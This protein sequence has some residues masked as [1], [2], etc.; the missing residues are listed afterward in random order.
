MAKHAKQRL[1]SSALITSD[2]VCTIEGHWKL[3]AGAPPPPTF[4]F[5][6]GKGEEDWSIRITWELADSQS[7]TVR[8]L[9][10]AM[11]ATGGLR[12]ALF[13]LRQECRGGTLLNYQG[14]VTGY[15]LS[16]H[17]IG[18]ELDA[19][20]SR[21]DVAPLWKSDEWKPRKEDI[22]DP[23]WW[24]IQAEYWADRGEYEYSDNIMQM[25]RG[26][27]TRPEEGAQDG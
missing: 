26:V 17:P 1:P 11:S 7:D 6:R 22:L 10:Q 20:L 9:W 27:L 23:V 8:R 19:V 13:I 16:L 15:H 12:G 21:D 4:P 3:V 24:G 5:F 18:R 25:V 14:V 2:D